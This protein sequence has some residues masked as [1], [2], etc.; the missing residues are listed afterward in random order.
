[1]PRRRAGLFVE[2]LDSSRQRSRGDE[3]VPL[4][5]QRHEIRV[6]GRRSPL[7]FEVRSTRHGPVGNP[8]D[9]DEIYAGAAPPP[10]GLGDTV[11][12]LKW[13]PVLEAN[14]SAAFDRL[15]R[16]GGW[17]AFVDAVR[18]FSA[19]PRT[20]LYVTST[21]ISAVSGLRR[22]QR[23]R[24]RVPVSGVSRDADWHEWCRYTPASA[25]C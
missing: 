11:L 8:D 10:E 21:A 16:A 22:L 14:S 4:A 5:V 25:V 2:Q 6:R 19:P 13:Q 23:L 7:V 15:A 17:E 24:R 1:M 12:A 3:W 20:S 9:W 18:Q